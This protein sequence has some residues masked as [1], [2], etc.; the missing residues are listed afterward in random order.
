M[1]MPSGR[2]WIVT[3]TAQHTGYA[4]LPGE[5]A[6]PFAAPES[7]VRKRAL[8][9]NAHLWVTQYDPTQ[10]NAAGYYPNQSKGGEGL[11]QWIRANRSIE[12]QDIVVWYTMGITH[13][14]RPEEWPVMPVHRAGFKLVPS[15]FFSRNPALD[16]PKQA[17]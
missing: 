14:P 15:G 17:G 8:F 9:L 16:V 6:V 11:P 2:K 13:V 1:D 10:I 5:N 3:N 12:N 4:L 7:W